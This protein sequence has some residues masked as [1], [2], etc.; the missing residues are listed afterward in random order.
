MMTNVITWMTP[1]MTYNTVR[2][3]YTMFLDS[4]MRQH[5]RLNYPYIGIMIQYGESRG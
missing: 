4:Q 1:V 5:N 3:G 2:Y